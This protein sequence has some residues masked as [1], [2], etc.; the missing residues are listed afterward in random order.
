M[1]A[2][3][4]PSAHNG[5]SAP[6]ERPFDRPPVVPLIPPAEWTN[7]QPRIANVRPPRHPQVDYKYRLRF[8]FI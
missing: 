6:Y 1:F 8:K 5:P 7:S 3:A 4:R 2:P